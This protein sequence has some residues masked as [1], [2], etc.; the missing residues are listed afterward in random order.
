LPPTCWRG[1]RTSERSTIEGFIGS[2]DDPAII[3]QIPRKRPRI[4]TVLDNGSHNN[5]HTISSFELL[6]EYLHPKGVYMVEDTHTCY[7]DEHGGGLRRTG[8]FIEHAKIKST[9]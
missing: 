2:Q 9:K 5:D 4:D 6:Y 8:S 1:G 7:W 3:Q